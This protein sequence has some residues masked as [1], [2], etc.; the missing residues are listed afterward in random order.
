MIYR[1]GQPI[2]YEYISSPWDLD[3]YQTVYA[4]EPG[5]AEM[6]SAGRAFTW[7]MLFDLKRQG[8]D[9]A[10]LTLHTGL[11]TY[12][13][14]QLDSLHPASEEEYYIGEITA[15]K[16]NKCRETNGRIIAVGTTVVRALESAANDLSRIAAGHDYTRLHIDNIHELRIADGLITGLHEPEAS[17]LDLLSAF[18]PPDL[19]R[20][21][22]EEAIHLGYLWHEFGDLNLII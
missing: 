19:I 21:A 13:D 16:I 9:S 6:P 14:D 15:N 18:I 17:H 10:Y 4:R 7:R 11:S 20:K 12:M 3:Y 8:I 2:R 22:Y 1:L 5:S